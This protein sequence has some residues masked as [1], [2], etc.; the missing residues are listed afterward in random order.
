MIWT[1]I[2]FWPALVT[3]WFLFTAAFMMGGLL[4]VNWQNIKFEH[5][6]ETSRERPS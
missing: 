5:D 2:S 4:W 1:N 6:Q 3:V